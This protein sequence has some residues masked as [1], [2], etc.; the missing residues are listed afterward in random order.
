MPDT[1][2][3]TVM[4]LVFVPTDELFVTVVLAVGFVVREFSVSE[5]FQPLYWNVRVGLSSP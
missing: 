1:P 5:F 4:A 3:E 2:P